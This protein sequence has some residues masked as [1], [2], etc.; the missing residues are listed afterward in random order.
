VNV[1]SLDKLNPYVREQRGATLQEMEDF[2][3]IT[4]TQAGEITQIPNWPIL[5]FDLNAENELMMYLR[6]GEDEGIFILDEKVQC[7]LSINFKGSDVKRSGAMWSPDGKDIWII[8]YGDNSIQEKC[9]SDNCNFR[10]DFC[11]F[12][13]L[14]T[15][16]LDSKA[17][18]WRKERLC[19]NKERNAAGK[20]TRDGA[21]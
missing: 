16:L 19:R 18:V 21:E 14:E 3:M 8:S 1:L 10:R 20:R 11:C 9:T 4:E 6:Y 15:T 7:T 5:S 13:F 12:L 17:E 2:L